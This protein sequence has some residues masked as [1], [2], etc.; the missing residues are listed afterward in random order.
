M[1]A[2]DL[3]VS[4]GSVVTVNSDNDVV[5]NASVVV[6]KGRIVDILP[7]PQG[8]QEYRPARHLQ[9]PGHI[10][11]P[12]LVNAHTHLAMNLFRGLADDLPLQPWLTEHI[13]PAEQRELSTDFVRTGTRLALVECVRAGVTCVND[14]YFFPETTAEAL[15]ES[16]MRGSVGMLVIDFPSAWAKDAAMYFQKGLALHD[17]LRG[18]P[19][20]GTCFAPHAPYSVQREHLEKIA[21]HSTE[22]DVPVHIHVHETAKEVSDFVSSHGIR[23]LAMLADLGLLSPSLIAVHMTQLNMDEIETL[24]AHGVNIVHCPESNMKLASG[25]APVGKLLVAGCNVAIGTDGAASNNDIDLLGELRTAGFLAK[26]IAEDATVCPA[27]ELLRMATIDGAK[28]LGIDDVTGS[29]ETGKSADFIALDTAAPE[30]QPIHSV[31]SQLVY[32]TASR[33]VTDVWVAGKCLMD[34]GTLTQ[35]DKDEI[36]ADAVAWKNSFN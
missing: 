20:I 18:N 22:L 27:P 3:M 28:A 17:N 8:L 6:D 30:M 5:E 19:L 25:A 16:G 29:L 1:N 13:W 23:P 2:C 26:L 10:L 33:Q 34:S 9:R 24:A 31:A 36:I 12:G 7:T 15:I 35:V 4:A 21:I 32:A 11:M 14:M